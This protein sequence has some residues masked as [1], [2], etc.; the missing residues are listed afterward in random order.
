MAEVFIAASSGEVGVVSFLGDE[1]RGLGIG[2]LPAGRRLRRREPREREECQEDEAPRARRSTVRSLPAPTL[3]GSA[4][5]A[6]S[7]ARRGA[8]AKSGSPP[9]GK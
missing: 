6:D 9:D 1:R 7:R 8:G 5:H 3:E 4:L 2:L